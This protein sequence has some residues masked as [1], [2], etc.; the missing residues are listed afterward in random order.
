MTPIAEALKK[1]DEEGEH[2]S[3]KKEYWQNELKSLVIEPK[4]QNDLNDKAELEALAEIIKE[5]YYQDYK[6]AYG[7]SNNN[8]NN[9]N[10]E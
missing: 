8:N 1:E 9:N 2:L 10:K 4:R 3:D 7:N 5:V 6:I